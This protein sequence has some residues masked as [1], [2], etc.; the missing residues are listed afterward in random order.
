MSRV[1]GLDHGRR[2]IG[3]AVGDTQTGLAFA[4]P[5]LIRRSLELDLDTITALARD[6][7]AELVVLTL[8]MFLGV[9]RDIWEGLVAARMTTLPLDDPSTF[10]MLAR[11]ESVGVFQTG[12]LPPGGE[13]RMPDAALDVRPTLG[14][15]HVAGDLLVLFRGDLVVRGQLFEQIRNLR[16]PSRFGKG[17]PPLFEPFHRAVLTL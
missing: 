12:T 4:R 7:E 14:E 15:Q 2:R 9:E 13:P 17:R 6:E 11:G 16:E 3:L 10:A 5:A 8:T 1:I